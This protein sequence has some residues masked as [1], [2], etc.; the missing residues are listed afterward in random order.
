MGPG[1]HRPLHKCIHRLQIL[2][3]EIFSSQRGLFRLWES[4]LQRLYDVLV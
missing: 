4:K 2:L 1:A 3:A